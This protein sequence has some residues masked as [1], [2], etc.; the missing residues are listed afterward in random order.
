MGALGH[1]L[2]R[3][4]RAGDLL[5]A[6]GRRVEV[7]SVPGHDHGAQVDPLPAAAYVYGPDAADQLLLPPVDEHG[8]KL[9]YVSSINASVTGVSPDGSLELSV[10]LKMGA[11]VESSDGDPNHVFPI[12]IAGTFSTAVKTPVTPHVPSGVTWDIGEPGLPQRSSSLPS[13]TLP[14][15][16]EGRTATIGSNSFT[17]DNTRLNALDPNT[18][19]G[20]RYLATTLTTFLFGVDKNGQD[21]LDNEEDPNLWDPG[22]YYDYTQNELPNGLAPFPD[23]SPGIADISMDMTIDR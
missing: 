15:A 13:K 19:S 9:L 18:Q 4:S 23:F 5:Q 10:G 14:G 6:A 17:F 22:H 2:R 8:N 21:I 7:H 11:T 20:Q 1:P 3:L 16:V 12:D